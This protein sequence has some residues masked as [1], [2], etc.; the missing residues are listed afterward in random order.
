M[1]TLGWSHVTSVDRRTD[2]YFRYM[3][4]P[5]YGYTEQNDQLDCQNTWT[6]GRREVVMA[7]QKT[8]AATVEW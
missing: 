7:V 8:T 3:Y 5:R 2:F 6:T 4:G 1:G